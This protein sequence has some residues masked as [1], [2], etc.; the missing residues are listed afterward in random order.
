MTYTDETR[1]EKIAFNIEEQYTDR[2]LPQDSRQIATPGV[3]GERTIKTRVY[4]S[5]GRSC[6]MKEL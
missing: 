3:Q 5:N 6:P 2:D 4:S 1:V